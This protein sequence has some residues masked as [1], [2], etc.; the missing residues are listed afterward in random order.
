MKQV[1]SAAVAIA[2]ITLPAAAQSGRDVAVPLPD[3]SSTQSGGNWV[4]GTCTS[5]SNT[6][7]ATGFL[8]QG[9]EEEWGDTIT[10]QAGT[11]RAVTD[12]TMLIF[13]LVGQEHPVDV[14]V[15]FFEGG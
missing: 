14:Q 8:I 11:G 5:Y 13:S 12:I 9:R 10:Q 1:I 15:R 2:S 3:F 6:T 4:F 7:N